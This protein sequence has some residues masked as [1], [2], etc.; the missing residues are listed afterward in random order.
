MATG[1]LRSP[2]AETNS[3]PFDQADANGCQVP[4][5]EP[6]HVRDVRRRGRRASSFDPD[7]VIPSVPAGIQRQESDQRCMFDTRDGLGRFTTKT[8]GLVP[9]A[10]PENAK[11]AE[12]IR[13][14][15]SNLASVTGR[16]AELRNWYGTGHGKHPR[17]Q[18][19]QPR[20]ARLAVGSATTLVTFLYE[21]HLARPKQGT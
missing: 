12:T 17:A 7:R 1:A 11:G 21:T 14:L 13:V 19:L 3:R 15:L 18:A 6:V 20:H 9:D 8:L 5:A 16:M 10:I 2:S 4:R